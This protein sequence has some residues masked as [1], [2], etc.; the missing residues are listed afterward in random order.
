[1][2][3]FGVVLA[4][5][6]LFGYLRLNLASF[7]QTVRVAGITSESGSSFGERWSAAPDEAA[8]QQV[9]QSH[10]DAYFSETEREARAGAQIVVWPELSGMTFDSDEAFYLDQ[11]QEVAR[12][13]GIYLTIPMGIVD[14]STG[15]RTENKLLLIDPT[16][17]IVFEHV[18]YGG[19]I[20][21]G[22]LLGDKK[23]RTVTTPFG[24]ISGAICYDMDFPTV[25]QQSGRNGTGLMLVPSSDWREIDPIHSQMAVFRAIENGTSMVRQVDHAL[26]IAVDPYGRVLAQTDF[27]SSSDRTLVAQVPVED[28]PTLY[29]AFGR[30]FEWLCFA[31]FLFVV[32]WSLIARRQAS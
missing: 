13:N 3:T 8:E 21:E 31:G 14:T 16:G 15:Q 25:I 22:G 4:V 12:E 24:V 27:Y 30:W 1:M 11:A 19:H 23:L 17:A 7:S 28:V 18:K 9:L 29:A 6:Y 10:W 32:G 5:V 26:S 20:I 2:A